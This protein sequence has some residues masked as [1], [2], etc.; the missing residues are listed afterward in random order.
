MSKLTTTLALLVLAAIL[1]V[2]ASIIKDEGKAPYYKTVEGAL[3]AADT[4]Q[5]V[6]VK[7]ETDWCIWC[8]VMDTGVFAKPKAIDFFSNKVIL[9]KVDAE[10]D[11][12]PAQKYKISGYP[13]SVLMD[14]Q[15]KEIDRIIGYLPADEYI[16]TVEDYANGI[17]T[18]D[19]MLHTAEQG[20]DRALFYDIGTKYKY[21][22]RSKE[23]ETW[24]NKVI[25]SGQPTDSMSGE[26]RIAIADM[27]R[28]AEEYDHSLASFE[29]IA[30]DFKTGMFA[31]TADIYRGI[32]LKAKGDTA[33]AIA[34]F[35]EFT[36]KYPESEDVEYAN[37]QI[38]K[39]K[40]TPGEGI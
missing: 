14:K 8:K 13:T 24:F 37:E 2:S 29:Q 40:K 22:G 30:S 7:F 27:Y 6:L 34:A 16:Q 33:S 39:L 23:A 31:E 20:S 32:V 17:G 1:T 12:I 5:L 25:A 36:V 15:G 18:L 28:R 4:D 38:D 3:K 11:T 26:S 10:K 35:E 19:D 9:A 21:S